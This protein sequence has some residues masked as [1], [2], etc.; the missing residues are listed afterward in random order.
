MFDGTERC[1]VTGKLMFTR[2]QAHGF[3][4]AYGRAKGVR[5]AYKNCVFCG[6]Y[7]TTK[8]VRGRGKS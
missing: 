5:G 1:G 7:H 2:E 4:A 3:L 8:N 6:H